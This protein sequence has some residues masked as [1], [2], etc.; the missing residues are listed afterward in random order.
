MTLQVLRV[1]VG[2]VAVRAREF[3]IRVFGRD[4]GVLRGAIDTVGDWGRAAGDAGQDAT[5]ALRTHDLRAWRFLG[6]V[7]RSVR[8]VHVRAHGPLLAIGVAKGT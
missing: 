1:K 4:R 7:G 8:A 5:T 6:S 2:L 3:A